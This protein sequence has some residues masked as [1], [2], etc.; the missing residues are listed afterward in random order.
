MRLLE[1]LRRRSRALLVVALL[2]LPAAP[3]PADAP[4][5]INGFS[6]DGVEM[7]KRALGLFREAGLELPSLSVIRSDS[8]DICRGRIAFH[9]RESSSSRIVLCDPMVEGR[10]WRILLHELAHAWASIGLSASRRDAFQDVRGYE[11]WRDYESAEWRDNGTEQAAEIVKWG[12]SDVPV[13]VFLD[14]DSCGQLRDGYVA[15]VG[16]EP[17]HGLPDLCA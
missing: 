11:H 14:D 9:R 16:A 10:E 1:P 2:A 15:L 12:L 8:N 3:R 17:L 5:E 6:A 13:P 4:V 7:V